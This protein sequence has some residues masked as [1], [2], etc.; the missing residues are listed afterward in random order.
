MP[1]RAD[2]LLRQAFN[3]FPFLL[4]QVI[5]GLHNFDA[6]LVAKVAKATAAGGGTHIDIACDPELVRAAKAVSDVPVGA[7]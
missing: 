4:L 6:E 5:S 2:R 7:A 3:A 1:W